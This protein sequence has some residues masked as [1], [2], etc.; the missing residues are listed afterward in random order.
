MVIGI[1]TDV[2]LSSSV[3]YEFTPNTV[4]RRLGVHMFL[5]LYQVEV[6]MNFTH[7]L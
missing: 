4:V 1:G 2:F 3:S 5:F 7:S 6:T